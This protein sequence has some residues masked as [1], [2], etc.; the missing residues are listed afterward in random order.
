[1][2]WALVV[3]ERSK[4]NRQSSPSMQHKLGSRASDPS[5]PPRSESFSS[6]GVQAARTPPMHRP[7]EPQVQVA[8]LVPLKPHSTSM[9][10]SQSLHEQP[11]KSMSGA[12]HSQEGLPAHRAEMPRQNSDPTSET[13]PLPPRT[14]A[15][16]EK[17]AGGA[18]FRQEE[19]IPPKVREQSL[20]SFSFSLFSPFLLLSLFRVFPLSPLLFCRSLSISLPLSRSLCIS[21]SFSTQKSKPSGAY[22]LGP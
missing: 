19:S 14:G 22:T 9:T 18:W 8:H 6:G 15:R 3:E 1:M 13:P 12:F 17:Y 11:T 4:L 2:T 7:V 20:D 16:E 10:A 21:L 5:M